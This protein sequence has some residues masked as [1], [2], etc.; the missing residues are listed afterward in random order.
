MLHIVVLAAIVVVVAACGGSQVASVEQSS[1]A[2]RA[3]QPAN[4]DPPRQQQISGPTLSPESEA[5]LRKALSPEAF[6]AIFKAGSRRES[7]EET[8]LIDECFGVEGS[9]GSDSQQGKPPEDQPSAQ[10]SGG[11]HGK[12]PEDQQRA[13][14]ISGAQGKE[15]TCRLS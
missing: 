3:Q 10:G 1:S 7:G 5:C 13:K 9:A 4:G 11:E 8:A 2:S 12:P 14:A 6:N 15:S